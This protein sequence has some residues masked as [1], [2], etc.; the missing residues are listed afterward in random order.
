MMKYVVV[1]C[2]IL[3]AIFLGVIT[4]NVAATASPQTMAVVTTTWKSMRDLIGLG[5]PRE[6]HIVRTLK[7]LLGRLRDNDF[8]AWDIVIA[9][10]REAPRLS[11]IYAGFEFLDGRSKAVDFPGLLALANLAAASRAVAIRCTVSP[12]RPNCDRKPQPP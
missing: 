3:S 5:D 4:N 1:V 6:D 10:R 9:V 12:D 2:A 11:P 7:P 8:P